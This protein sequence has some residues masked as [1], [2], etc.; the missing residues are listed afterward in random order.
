MKALSGW[1]I[2]VGLLLAAT[3]A[4]AQGAPQDAGRSGYLPASDL[5]G[6]SVNVPPVQVEVPPPPRVIYGAPAYGPPAYGPPPAYGD[7]D[8]GPGY[9]SG[10]QL[11]PPTEIYAV[12]RQNGFSPLGAPRLRGFFYSVSAIDRRGDDGHLVIDARNGRIVR[13]MPAEHFDGYGGYGDGYYG[14]Y[15]GP[16]RPSYGPLEPMTRLDGTHLDGTRLDGQPRPSTAAQ[17]KIASRMPPTVPV[18]KVAPARPGVEQPV[19]AK[20]LDQP[21]ATKPSPAPVQ[22]AAIAVKRADPPPAPPVTPVEIK[23]TAPVIQPTQPMPKVQD[24]E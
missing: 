4:H 6:P 12:L 24:F 5:T 22:S 3:A 14:G 17:P 21:V 16:P 20:P 11:L 1:T 9:Y 8:V 13:F 2:S 7:P 23:P 15:G 10:P 19:A 18:P